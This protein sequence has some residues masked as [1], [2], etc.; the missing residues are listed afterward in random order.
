MIY[1]PLRFGGH[2]P[3]AL[4]PLYLMVHTHWGQKT[5]SNHKAKGLKNHS[6]TTSRDTTKSYQKYIIIIQNK[7]SHDT[8]QDTYLC[9]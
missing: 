5:V 3:S 8:G 2:G 4:A 7:D 9:I 1:R 6:N